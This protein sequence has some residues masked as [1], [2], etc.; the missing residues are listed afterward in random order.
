VSGTRLVSENA[1]AA[2]HSLARPASTGD[3]A[4]RPRMTS[5]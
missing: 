3:G 1:C 2:H 5:I 4:A